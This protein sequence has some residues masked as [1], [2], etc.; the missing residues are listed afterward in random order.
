MSVRTIALTLRPSAEQAAV[1]ERLQQQFNAAC[2]AISQQAWAAKEFRQFSLHP[3]VY[4]TVREQFGLLAQ[5]AIRAIAVVADSYRADKSCP[6]TFRPDGAVVL[7]T[8]RLYRLRATL[9][10]IATLDG[11]IEVPLAIGG[12]Q[13]AQLAAAAKLAEAD[14]IRDEKG[15]WRLLVSAHYPDAPVAD[16]TDV[17]G[18]DLGIVNIAADSDGTVYSGAQLRALRH[19][20]PRLRTRLQLRH[21]ASARKLRHKRRRREARFA[22]DVNHCLSKRIVAV[23]ERTERAVAIEELGGIRARVTATRSQRATLHS[24]SFDQLRSFIEYKAR[25]HGVLV[26]GVDPRNSSRTCPSCGGIDKRNRPSQSCFS[27]VSCGFSGLADSIAATV[28]RQ[29][30]RAV[31]NLPYIPF[32]GVLNTGGT[33]PQPLGVGC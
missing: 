10:S 9:A 12:H 7:D 8:P 18:V 21:T 25:M 31:V 4:T 20:H 1:L 5:H 16:P 11:R 6:H 15:R 2:N 26:V 19:R 30:G 3:L 23:A 24:W 33:S 22:K 27:C 14:L 13:R 17:L 29:R 32:S 28:L